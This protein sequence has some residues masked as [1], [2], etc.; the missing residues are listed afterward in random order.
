M[1]QLGNGPFFDRQMRHQFSGRR[2]HLFIASEL[3]FFPLFLTL[4]D[5][6]IGNDAVILHI[7]WLNAWP[8]V[9]HGQDKEKNG[10]ERTIKKA[11]W[12]KYAV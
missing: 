3:V 5:Y 1:I 9:S 12:P 8:A 11:A 10:E 7:C 2:S 4:F 6:S